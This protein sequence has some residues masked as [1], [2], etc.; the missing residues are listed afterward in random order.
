MTKLDL[1]LQQAEMSARRALIGTG[2]K[3]PRWFI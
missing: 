3:L 1:L 2:E